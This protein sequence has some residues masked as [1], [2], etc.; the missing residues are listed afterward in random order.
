MKKLILIFVISAFLNGC[1]TY[2]INSTHLDNSQPLAQNHGV[3]AL[4]VIN[5][6]ARLAPLH[7]GWTEVIAI[8]MDNHEQI[9]Q[10]AIEEAK[11]KAAA[12]NKAFNADEVE[13]DP[14]AYTFS[15]NS[16]GVV[17][18][19]LFAGS[20]PEGEYLIASLYS[21]YS[22][23]NMSSW[24][25]MPVYAS[26][27]TFKVKAGEFTNLGS[28]VFQ[29]LLNIKETSFWS[30]R[31]SSKAYV[32]RISE[33]ENLQDFIIEH[34][35]NLASS[36]NFNQ[37]LG[38]EDDKFVELRNKLSAL[39]RNNAYGSQALILQEHNKRAVA[40]KFGQLHVVNS[41]DSW[42][43][44]DLPTNGQLT[45]VLELDGKILVGSERGQVFISDSLQGDWTATQPVSAAESIIWF[46]KAEETLFAATA[47]AKSHF[48]YTINKDDLSW[49][50][51]GN[52][53]RKNPNDFWV[54]N[55]GLFPILTANGQL[56]VLNDNKLYDFTIESKQWTSVK[57]SPMVQ[58]SQ[59]ANGV[60]VGLEVSQW[61]GVGD[62]AVSFDYGQSWTSLSRSLKAFG[63]NTTD[64]SLPIVLGDKTLI[65][66]GRVDKTV[67]QL[68]IISTTTNGEDVSR[69]DWIMRGTAKPDCEIALPKLTNGQRIYFLC[70]QGQIVSTDDF[71]QTWKTN[72][73][74]DIA[75]MQAEY[76]SL[77]DALKQQDE[78]EPQ[79][80]EQ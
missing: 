2:E 28:L 13:W 9:K 6:T 79:E 14:E 33:A 74:M 61:D 57:S 39:S 38:W 76:E 44:I 42:T 69:K 45:S 10:A 20:M 16:Q 50:R 43:Q 63:D 78:K 15:P 35:P 53:E 36:V 60:L 47:S 49:Q 19:Q 73:E 31:S 26:A 51:I 12:K 4:Q 72:V 66:L 59:L 55:G 68:Q 52:F 77:L 37:S 5:N 67:K 46:G 1:A 40:A 17:D 24:L 30:N 71:G 62:Q 65:T 34:F 48:F 25:T 58:V 56:R 27:G 8:R 41:D 54:Q 21:F 64:R 32:T 80:P 29:P 23:G 70:D 22:D 11:A 18:S 3:V 7:P 75:A